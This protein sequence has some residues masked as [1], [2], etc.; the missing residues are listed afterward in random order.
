MCNAELYFQTGY[1]HENINAIDPAHYSL[2]FL[3]PDRV[4]CPAF[5]I[6]LEGKQLIKL[7]RLIKTVCC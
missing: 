7:I 2:K 3:H 1:I 5:S 6:K 4:V